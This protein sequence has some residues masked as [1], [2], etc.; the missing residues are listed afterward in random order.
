MK[1]SSLSKFIT[2]KL[3]LQFQK[4]YPLGNL[5]VTND[6]KTHIIRLLRISIRLRR[7][8][9]EQGRAL[10]FKD[11]AYCTFLVFLQQGQCHPK[12]RY[13]HSWRL[14]FQAKFLLQPGRQWC[15]NQIFFFCPFSPYKILIAETPPKDFSEYTWSICRPCP[16]LHLAIYS[17][18]SQ[19]ECSYP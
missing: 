9:V 4:Q 13:S 5:K 18:A 6:N 16:P 19:A 17:L 14:N 7:L 11:H 8:A 15:E 12:P 10:G 2:N 3:T 1:Y